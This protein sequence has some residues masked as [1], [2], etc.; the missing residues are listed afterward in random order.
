MEA[1]TGEQRFFYFQV[2]PRK[3]GE[4]ASIDAW[5]L[6]PH[7]ISMTTSA[8][9]LPQRP[10]PGFTPVPDALF[11]AVFPDLSPSELKVYLYLLRRTL[12][13]GRRETWISLSQMAQGIRNRS[14]ERLDRGA[15]L[16]PRTIQRAIKSLE[17]RGLIRIRA[18]RDARGHMANLYSLAAMPVETSSDAEMQKKD[19]TDTPLTASAPPPYGSTATPL[20]RPDRNIRE[21]VYRDTEKH[22][23][24]GAQAL[25]SPLDDVSFSK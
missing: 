11:D 9:T 20:R 8:A 19:T 21:T 18:R 16:H 25:P 6:L 1:N 12:G 14:G 22:H 2:N 23:Q 24:T 10:S 5:R 17:G 15:C 3:R 13:F 4:S 7:T